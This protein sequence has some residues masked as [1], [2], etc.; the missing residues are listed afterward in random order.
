MLAFGTLK[1]VNPF[2]SWYAT[3]IEQSGLG[4]LSYVMGI[5]GEIGVGL[6]LLLALTLGGKWLPQRRLLLISVA[7]AAVVVMM[8]VGI[9]V[10]LQPAVPAEV[11]P[12]KIKPPYIPGFF[13]VLA[14]AN[15]WLSLRET[16]RLRP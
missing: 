13:W 7:S 16:T 15:V 5:A 12:M 14:V 6:A 10:H 1:F 4:D 2:K 8:S 11:L 3:Q 9:W